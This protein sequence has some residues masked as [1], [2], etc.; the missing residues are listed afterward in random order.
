MRWISVYKAESNIISK[1]TISELQAYGN[2]MRD[3]ISINPSTDGNPTMDSADDF[4]LLENTEDDIS[5]KKKSK[6]KK[7]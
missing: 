3:N 5:V 4:D 2:I 1:F 7:S 6:K